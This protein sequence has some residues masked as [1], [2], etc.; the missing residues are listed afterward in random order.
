MASRQSHRANYPTNDVETYYRLSIY[1]PIIE[2]VLV[3][4]KS[5]FSEETVKLYYFSVLFPDSIY[6]NDD[7][8]LQEAVCELATRYHVFFNEPVAIVQKR[9]HDEL[10]L[11]KQ[12]WTHN[13]YD[14]T[15]SAIQLIDHCDSDIYP[16]LHTLFR[17][18]ITL[19]ISNASSERCFSSLR[20]TKTWLRATMIEERLIGLSLLNIH[21]TI[22]IDPDK[23]IDRYAK[24][25]KHRLEFV[26]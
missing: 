26:L 5:R 24:I 11:W 9:I 25:Y 19:P 21:N 10:T 6:L 13:K 16:I 18:F 4:L 15:Y 2:S 3:D 8:L 1:I 20:R 23:I 14:S 12:K 17:I 22:F 7:G